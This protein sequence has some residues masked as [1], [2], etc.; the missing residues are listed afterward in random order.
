MQSQQSARKMTNSYL[1]TVQG[2]SGRTYLVD[3][4]GRLIDPE[5][6]MIYD[7][8]SHLLIDPST[9]MIVNLN[10]GVIYDANGNPISEIS[11][12]ELY[13]IEPVTTASPQTV[14]FSYPAQME[15]Y[16][17]YYPVQ[18]QFV[19]YQDNTEPITQKVSAVVKKATTVAKKAA[20]KFVKTMDNL[21][22]SV[23]PTPMPVE[24]NS[25]YQRLKIG[26]S[27]VDDE[28]EFLREVLE[29]LMEY[30]EATN[31]TKITRKSL[32]IMYPGADKKTLKKV[33]AAIKYLWDSGIVPPAED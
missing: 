25:L 2:P 5:T 11:L 16:A 3:D 27:R 26:L 33:E 8:T 9:G 15:D 4:K 32:K 31:A 14:S 6:G 29:K 7:P 28:A 10:T 23:N 13:G 20:T 30:V 19:T 21:A 18:G 24:Y 22:E 12:Q 17:Y 1:R